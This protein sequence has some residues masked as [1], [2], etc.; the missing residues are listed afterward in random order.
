MRCRD[1]SLIKILS[2]ALIIVVLGILS[3]FVFQALPD[4]M[5]VYSYS[6]RFSVGYLAWL[7]IV[8][9]AGLECLRQFQNAKLFFLLGLCA[10]VFSF[11]YVLASSGVKYSSGSFFSFAIGIYREFQSAGFLVFLTFFV[12]R[13]LSIIKR[14]P[15]D[16]AA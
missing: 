10:L 11:S 16:D 1:F 14:Q 4:A 8:V 3:L 13:G 15:K 12:V 5:R 2:V 7:G 9:L 6:L